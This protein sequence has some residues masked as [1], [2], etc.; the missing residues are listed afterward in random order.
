M[1]LPAIPRRWMA[2]GRKIILK[3]VATRFGPASL[4]T[5][6]CLDRNVIRAKI[7]C[8]SG[9][10]PRKV[11]IRLPHPA[12]KKA[13]AVKGGKYDPSAESVTISPFKGAAKIELRF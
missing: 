7:V 10:K 13:S 11:V 9:R 12:G 6:S 2:D 8:R 4:E 5:E 3:D 1:L